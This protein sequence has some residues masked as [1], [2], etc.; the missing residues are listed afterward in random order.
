[1]TSTTSDFTQCSDVSNTN[2]EQVNA[3][4]KYRLSKSFLNYRIG[5]FAKFY[6]EDT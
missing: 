5:K 2:S 6:A 1:M 4:C 3:G